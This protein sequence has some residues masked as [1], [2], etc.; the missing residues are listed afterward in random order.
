MPWDTD[1]SKQLDT[2][3]APYREQATQ[4][5][6]PYA[7]MGQNSWLAQ[8]H[9]H[10]GGIADNAFLTAAMTPGP[11]GPEGVG[12]GISRTF[13]GLLGAQQFRRDRALQAAMLPYQMLQPRLQAEHT[14]A[15]IGQQEASTK[16]YG[17]HAKYLADMTDV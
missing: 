5:N 2:M 7:T 10:L 6:S 12:G 15:Q 9:P 1:F 16:Y 14:M 3:L 8:N 13:Q 11:Q 17:A 4:F